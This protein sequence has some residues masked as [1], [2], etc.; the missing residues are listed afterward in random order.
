MDIKKLGN[1]LNKKVTANEIVNSIND[2]I[3]YLKKH[4]HSK[5][6]INVVV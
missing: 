3:L 2:E 1:K 4:N 5:S 6:D